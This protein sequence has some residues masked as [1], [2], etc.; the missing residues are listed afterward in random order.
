MRIF[1]FLFQLSYFFHL[2]INK[3]EQGFVEFNTQNSILMLLVLNVFSSKN[4]A[5]SVYFTCVFTNVSAIM[6]NKFHLSRKKC[7]AQYIRILCNSVNSFRKRD[8]SYMFDRVLNKPLH[9][10]SKPLNTCSKSTVKTS[11]YWVFFFKKEMF[12]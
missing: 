6:L 8:T 1:Y 11:K 5:N 9:I 10:N 4:G 7:Y 12:S 3:N 2:Q